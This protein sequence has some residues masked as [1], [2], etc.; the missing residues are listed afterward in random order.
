MSPSR[1]LWHDSPYDEHG[2][3]LGCETIDYDN[4]EERRKAM[5]VDKY[6]EPIPLNDPEYQPRMMTKKYTGQD[7][8]KGLPYGQKGF[9][10]AL[11]EGTGFPDPDVEVVDIE[12]PGERRELLVREADD[13]GFSETP[14]LPKVADS[15]EVDKVGA[16]DSKNPEQEAHAENLEKNED[17]QREDQEEQ[18][19]PDMSFL[20]VLESP[21]DKKDE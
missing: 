20:H 10:S 16:E 7:R 3:P 4:E 1:K 15:E 11:L 6:E 14:E 9:N 21:E 17:E 8:N 5:V 13:K 12:D 2:M 19:E 18:R